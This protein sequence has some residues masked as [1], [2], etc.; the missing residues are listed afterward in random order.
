MKLTLPEF[1]RVQGVGLYK[2]DLGRVLKVEKDEAHVRLKPRIQTDVHVLDSSRRAKLRPNPSFLTFDFAKQAP[3]INLKPDVDIK[4]HLGIQTFEYD[5]C[6]YCARTG[7]IIK[8]IALN[9]LDL[10]AKPTK[11]EERLF[12]NAR[13]PEDYAK[14]LNETQEGK[15][16]AEAAIL[17]QEE[18]LLSGGS[19]GSR[20]MF[21]L[22]DRV[23][24]VS[25][26][27]KGMVAHVRRSLP[28][29]F[30]MLESVRESFS[31]NCK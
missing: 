26:Q 14:D 31:N 21:G 9:K 1:V 8:K 16:F 30:L 11:A 10:H 25:G 3:H 7:H 29:G 4:L 24:V 15:D 18:A 2:G 28:N 27:L 20:N 17:A 6:F 23:K 19:L 22:G 12:S 13:A 5:D